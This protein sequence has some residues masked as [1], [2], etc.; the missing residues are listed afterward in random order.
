M[1]EYAIPS[2]LIEENLA[3]YICKLETSCLYGEWGYD[4][5]I[6]RKAYSIPNWLDLKGRRLPV[7]G[8]G[9][10]PAYENCGEMSSL[11]KLPEEE[12]P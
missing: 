3:A 5:V 4:I 12:G 6:D 9:R 2:Y 11:C 10:K 7:I 8:T 1:V